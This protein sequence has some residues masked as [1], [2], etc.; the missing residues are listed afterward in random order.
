MTRSIPLTLALMLFT[1]AIAL[2]ASVHVRQADGTWVEVEATEQ[3]GTVGFT[4]SP[5]QADAGRALVVINKPD[6]MV[7]EDETPPTI[8]SYS[9]GGESVDIEATPVTIEGLGDT[10]EQRRVTL[11]IGDDANPVDAGSALL[12]IKGRPSVSPEIVGDDWDAHSAELMIDL[13]DFG[14]GAW[15]GTLEVSDLSP[16]ANTVTLPLSFSIAGAQIADN[17][18]TITLSGGGTGFTVRADKRETVAV[19]AAG[20]SAF[21]SL[22]P[23]GEKHLYTREFTDVR[24]LGAQAG[25]HLVVAD[26]AM[27]DIDGKPVTDDEVGT[28]LSYQFAVHNDIPAIVVTTVA[29]NLAAPRSMYAF[30]GWLGGDGFVTSDGEVQEWS[31][32][33]DDIAPDRWILLPSK[34]D[35]Q[36]GVGWISGG[37]FGQSRFGTM[38]LYTDPRKPEVATGEALTTTF[39]LMPATDIDEV[40]EVARRLVQEGALEL[41]M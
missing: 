12:R 32:G 7:L 5:E 28:N 22:Q 37:D 8:P 13:N 15:E 9:V 34:A 33:Y 35:G 16:L 31:M 21:L 1:G 30:W 18:Q 10:A 36:P 3:D 39:A 11:T 20:V 23:S 6:W 25:W 14:P 38:L 41:G 26:V 19:D 40:A 2:A 27:E 24:S 17:Q 4:V 29:T